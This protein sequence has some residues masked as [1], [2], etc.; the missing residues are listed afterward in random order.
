[1]MR[2]LQLSDVGMDEYCYVCT[3]IQLFMVN[4]RSPELMHSN[5]AL[6]ITDSFS[7]GIYLHLSKDL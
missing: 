2:G 4:I 5:S 1:M 3:D 7:R 6:V